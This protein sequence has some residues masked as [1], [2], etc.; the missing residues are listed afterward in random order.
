MSDITYLC[1]VRQVSELVEGL[2]GLLAAGLLGCRFSRLT[3]CCLAGGPPGLLGLPGCRI[4]EP[5]PRLGRVSLSVWAKICHMSSWRGIRRLEGCAGLRVK[6]IYT[7]DCQSASWSI[8]SFAFVSNRTCFNRSTL[9]GVY[10]CVRVCVC[11]VRGWDIPLE[12][13]VLFVA[14]LV[15]DNAL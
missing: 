2:F 8:G 11:A 9:Q 5:C 15:P 13:L 1:H 3:G 7:H 12:N 4:G 10:V 6:V 14:V